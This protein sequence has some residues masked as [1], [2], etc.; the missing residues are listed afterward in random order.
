MSLRYPIAAM[1]LAG[2]LSAAPTRAG[3]DH[4]HDHGHDH[5]VAPALST[6]ALPRF[7]ASSADFELV[8]VLD[9][10]ALTLYLDRYA[11]NTPVLD[12]EI[13]LDLGGTRLKAVAHDDHYEVTLPAV[14]EP[15]M[16]PL[17]AA[18]STAE[19][20]DVLIGELDLHAHAEEA[21]AV[22]AGSRLPALAGWIVAALLAAGWLRASRIG[23]G[24][25]A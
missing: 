24:A 3:G 11:D 14:P 12:A 22:P 23:R 20:A 4:D 6:P 15:G 9:G 17:I 5:D 13:E 16:L 8:G 18:I 25:R 21:A 2:L 19:T 7:A 1:L 10:R